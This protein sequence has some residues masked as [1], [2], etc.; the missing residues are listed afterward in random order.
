MNQTIKEKNQKAWVR[1]NRKRGVA[2]TMDYGGGELTY[3]IFSEKGGLGG[4]PVFQYRTGADGLGLVL[5][6]PQDYKK[7][8]VL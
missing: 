3:G 2:A 6:S 8:K 5:S 4:Q 1:K 7:C